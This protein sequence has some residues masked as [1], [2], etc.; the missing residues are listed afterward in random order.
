MLEKEKGVKVD[1]KQEIERLELQIEK[2][3]QVNYTHMKL[4]RLGPC[5]ESKTMS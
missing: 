3:D 4:C 5:P 1:S 2:L